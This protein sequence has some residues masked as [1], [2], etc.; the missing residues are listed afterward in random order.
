[1]YFAIIYKMSV[2]QSTLAT[3]NYT[4]DTAPVLLETQ[5]LTNQTQI[6]FSKTFSSKY[7]TYEIVIFDV[8]SFAGLNEMHLQLSDSFGSSFHTNYI[9]HNLITYITPSGIQVQGNL[10]TSIQLTDIAGGLPISTSTDSYAGTIRIYDC[11]STTNNKQLDLRALYNNQ[12][13]AFVSLQGLAV[14]LSSVLPI[15]AFKIFSLSS[16]KFKS[17]FVQLWGVP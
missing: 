10:A 15:N 9:Y 16:I 8:S 11:L 14:D 7:S 13:N 5:S 1:M 12:Y 6:I 2:A 17:G 3:R 4:V